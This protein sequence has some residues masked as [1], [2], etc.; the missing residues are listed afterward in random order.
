MDDLKDPNEAAAYL[1]AAFEVGDREAFLQA[2][3]H[4]AEAQSDMSRLAKTASLNR[5]HLYRM[6]SNGGNS[7]ITVSRPYCRPLDSD[8][9]LKLRHSRP[10]HSAS[11]FQTI[12][13]P[14]DT[15]RQLA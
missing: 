7:A 1:G 6:L 13:V 12:R 2:V 8:Y 4:V 11:I 5:E 14:C 3:R 10:H 15:T 9:P